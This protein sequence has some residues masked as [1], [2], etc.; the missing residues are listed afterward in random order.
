MARNDWI[1]ILVIATLGTT[2]AVIVII[3]V[4]L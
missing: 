3:I 4:A 2:A 1:Q